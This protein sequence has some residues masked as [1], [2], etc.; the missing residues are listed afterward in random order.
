MIIYQLLYMQAYLWELQKHRVIHLGFALLILNLVSLRRSR[1]GWPF[2][3]SLLAAGVGVTL[4][5]TLQYQTLAKLEAFVPDT[6]IVL[7]I[8]AALLV[9]IATWQQFGAAFPI[10]AAISVGYMFFGRYVPGPLSAPPV[11]F[12]H[13]LT[14]IGGNVAGESGVYGS[15]LSL[16]ANYLFLFIVF[17][18]F[19]QAFGGLKFIR[20]AGN[21]VSSKLRSGPAALSVITSALLGTMTGSTVANITITGSFTIPMMKSAGFKP[22][23]AGAIEAAASNGG[24]ILPPVMGAAAFIMAG[25]TGIPYI[26]IVKAAAVPALIY[27]GLVLLYVQLQAG[28][29]GLQTTPARVDIKELLF[30]APVFLVP[31]AV[32]MV[33]LVKGYSLMFTGFWAVLS[34]VIVGLLS[35]IRGKAILK[36][37]WRETRDT[38]VD[39]THMACSMAVVCGLLGL[40]V[41][42]IQMTGL[43]V[44]LGQVL[45]DIAGGSLPL[46]LVFTAV[47]A[48][49]LGMGL[50]TAVA[51]ILTAVVLSPALI[52]LGVPPLAAH[53]FPLFFAVYCHLTPPVAVGALVASRMAGARYWLTCGE[54][55]KAAFVGLLIPVWFIY[56][57]GINLR[58]D[59]GVLMG[60]AQIL[61]IVLMAVS[62]QMILMRWCATAVK[63]Y[64][65][66]LLSMS[67]ILPLFFVFS[68]APSYLFIVT[69]AVSLAAAVSL[70]RRRSV[71]EQRLAIG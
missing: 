66:A 48:L 54:A 8:V 71:K 56:G 16:S 40:V 65:I 28:R 22:E 68:P 14:W 44:V 25:F 50:P 9:S 49:V 15:I 37:N 62:L 18:S 3:L 69:G 29:M 38:I 19:L 52:K 47:V 46:L 33:L 67:V 27:F 43:A 23:Q 7:G 55:L 60:M 42:G 39:G 30:D 64:E 31:L 6:A 24:Q 51:Y 10:L 12:Q 20:A 41:T 63:P 13:V 1:R 36:W 4:Y 35:S 26:S 32:L 58:F 59:G 45:V 53:L 61:S 57:P 34:C 17:G 2:K 5:F 70:N 21:I 11:P